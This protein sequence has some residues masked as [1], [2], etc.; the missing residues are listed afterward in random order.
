MQQNNPPRVRCKAQTERVS[1]EVLRLGRL[2]NVT[3]L[4][5]ELARADIEC[6]MKG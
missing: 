4:R 5:T 2:L 6:T 3:Q 1:E